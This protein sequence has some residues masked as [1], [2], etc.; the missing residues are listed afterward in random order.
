MSRTNSNNFGVLT[1]LV[2]RAAA[3]TGIFLLAA[4]IVMAW[5]ERAH[6]FDMD[7]EA[8]K[9][10]ESKGNP[11]AWDKGDDSRGLYQVT[12]VCLKEYNNFHPKA[13]Y[14]MDDLW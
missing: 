12:P 10:I 13:A 6:A 1:E 14:T 5:Y 3:L 11:R 9:Y 2:L 7:M 8:I 4:V